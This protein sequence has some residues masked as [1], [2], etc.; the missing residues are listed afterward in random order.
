MKTCND[1]PVSPAL[2]V[3][4]IVPGSLPKGCLSPCPMLY[5]NPETYN[6][7]DVPL[8]TCP[9]SWGLQLST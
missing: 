1:S 2:P 3:P 9:Y 6:F 7:M 5:A 4:G 8:F